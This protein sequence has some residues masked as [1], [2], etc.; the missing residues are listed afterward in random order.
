MRKRKP[1]IAVMLTVM[2]IISAMSST[3]AASAVSVSEVLETTYA[4]DHPR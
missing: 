3:L 1:L 2:F 4:F